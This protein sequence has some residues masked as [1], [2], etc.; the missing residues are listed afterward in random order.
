MSDRLTGNKI[1]I[2]LG[3]HGEPGMWPGLWEGPRFAK[4]IWHV[5]LFL[6]SL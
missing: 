4:Q 1:E 5:L 3:I 2:G 6:Y